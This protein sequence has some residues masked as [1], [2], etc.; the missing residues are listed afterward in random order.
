[1][2]ARGATV[3]PRH[4]G[5]WVF[6]FGSTLVRR[7]LDSVPLLP[8]SRLNVDVSKGGLQGAPAV[9]NNPLAT[10]R[11]RCLGIWLM[12]PLNGSS[13]LWLESGSSSRLTTLSLDI[14]QNSPQAVTDVLDI[15]HKL[16]G[17]LTK[18]RLNTDRMGHDPEEGLDNRHFSRTLHLPCL[19]A[20]WCSVSPSIASQAFLLG[21]IRGVQ[22]DQLLHLY[23]EYPQTTLTLLPPPLTILS[24]CGEGLRKLN[25]RVKASL[26]H[27]DRSEEDSPTWDHQ[28]TIASVKDLCPH[29]DSISL[30]HLTRASAIYIASDFKILRLECLDLT[31][32]DYP[33]IYAGLSECKCL[34]KIYL[35]HCFQA[36]SSERTQ[37]Q[38]L[39]TLDGAWK[40]VGL[41]TCEEAMLF[42][43]A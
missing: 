31:V 36:E 18:L 37:V 42:T 7:W 14:R 3:H 22:E 11:P 40:Y 13:W 20:L 43:R 19:R 8:L 41:S 5:N 39:F 24:M 4:T 1:M 15:L 17:S 27:S 34:E 29:L 25:L 6:E 12:E 33:L 32:S 23:L 10:I 28:E 2:A 38:D 16:G 26:F 21:I 30:N 35:R 9:F